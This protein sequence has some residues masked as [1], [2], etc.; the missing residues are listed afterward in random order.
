MWDDWTQSLW[1]QITGEAIV[2]ELTGTKLTPLGSAIVRWKDFAD[3][4]PAGDVLGLDQGFGIPY[5]ANPYVGYSSRERPYP[6][7]EGEIDDRYPALERVVGVTLQDASKAYPFSVIALIGVVNDS[8]DEVPIVVFWGAPDT[9]DAL[10]S[11]AIPAGEGIGTGVAFLSTVEGDKLTF[12]A[13][14]DDRFRD[15]ETGS[16][17]TLLGEAI[18]G[19]LSGTRLEIATHRNEFWFAWQAFFPQAEVFTG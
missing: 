5:G 19:P 3:A 16:T 14:G 6:F 13:L 2:G 10:D 12:E 1:Q 4:H 17:W 7:F 11:A 15:S 8:V 18:D 9:A